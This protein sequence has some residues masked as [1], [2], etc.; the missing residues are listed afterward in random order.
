MSKKQKQ[1]AQDNTAT[2]CSDHNEGTQCAAQQKKKSSGSMKK[3]Q[4]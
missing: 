4:N 1:Q 3:G 2:Q